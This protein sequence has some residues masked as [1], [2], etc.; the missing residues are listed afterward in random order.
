MNRLT[1]HPGQIVATSGALSALQD[2][3]EIA[4]PYLQRH[5]SGNWGEL[6]AGDWRENEV[7]LQHDLRLLSAYSLP[8]GQRIRI[9]DRLSTCVLLREEY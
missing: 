2:A 4:L 5:L 1:F 7:S 3:G 8:M 6:N 9:F